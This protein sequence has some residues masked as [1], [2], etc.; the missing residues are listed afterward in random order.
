MN[1]D[2][3]FLPNENLISQFELSKRELEILSL[4]VK[5]FSNQEIAESLF[6]SIST[7]K[8][9]NQK[10]FEKLDVNSR[11][12]AVEKAKRLRLVH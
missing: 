1:Q 6:I 12:K 2:E 11:L 10:L 5:G 4:L 9:H 3:N 8:T 7:V